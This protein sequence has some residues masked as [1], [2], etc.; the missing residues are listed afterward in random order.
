M[1]GKSQGRKPHLRSL[2][3][4]LSKRCLSPMPANPHHAEE[5]YMIEPT[6]VARLCLLSLV[7]IIVLH[8]IGLNKFEL[9]LNFTKRKC[10]CR[11]RHK[12]MSHIYIA[13]LQDIYSEALSTMAFILCSIN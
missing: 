10:S 2:A 11:C 6:V 12:Y 4:N 8:G 5:A 13:P 7:F 1:L 9:N 3:N